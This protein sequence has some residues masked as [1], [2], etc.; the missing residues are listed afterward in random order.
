[1]S[2]DKKYLY[3]LFDCLDIEPS[4]E[5]IE[6]LYNYL[7]E[8]KYSVMNKD[9]EKFIVHKTTACKDKSKW[10]FQGLDKNKKPKFVQYTNAVLSEV[11]AFLDNKNVKHI[12]SEK[13]LKIDVYSHASK[14]F[15]YYTTGRWAVASDNYTK[16]TRIHYRSKGIE[17]FYKRFLL[18]T[19]KK[20]EENFKEIYTNPRYVYDLKWKTFPSLH[21]YLYLLTLFSKKPIRFLS[22]DKLKYIE[23]EQQYK[24]Y[25]KHRGY[26]REEIA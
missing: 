8:N 9:L 1:M 3:G 5:E 21:L 10:H 19:L 26:R 18:T 2:N 24:I 14:Y 22:Y 4:E 12:I 16:A 17:D 15:Y 11:S 23:D 25:Q 7:K 13:A 20:E 6:D